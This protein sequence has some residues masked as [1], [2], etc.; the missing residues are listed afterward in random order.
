VWPILGGIAF[1]DTLTTPAHW[2]VYSQ[3]A[4]E[5]Q[6]NDVDM[7]DHTTIHSGASSGY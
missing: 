4:D 7:L 2:R 3:R 5:G 1:S 6:R